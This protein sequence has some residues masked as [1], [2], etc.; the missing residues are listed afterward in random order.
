MAA[1]RYSACSAGQMVWAGAE[2]PVLHTVPGLRTQYTKTAQEP[3]SQL[4]VARHA[5]AGCF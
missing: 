3:F 1:C 5:K 4:T 2:D